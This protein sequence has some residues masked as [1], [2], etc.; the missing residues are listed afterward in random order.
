VRLRGPAHRKQ[1]YLVG[2]AA[3]G[4]I[5]LALV[6]LGASS[7]RVAEI[8]LLGAGALVAYA[9]GYFLQRK[10]RRVSLRRRLRVAGLGAVMIAGLLVALAWNAHR[11]GELA[12]PVV[13][14][15]L[16]ACAAAHLLGQALAYRRRT[17]PRRPARESALAHRYLDGLRGVKI[18]GSIHNP[19]GLNTLNADYTASTDT[20]FKQAE[21]EITGKALPVDIVASGDELPLGNESVDFVV[22]SHVLEHLPDPI[23]ALNEW[24]RVVRPGGYVF[25]IVPHKERTFD[26]DRPRTALAE[27]VHRHETGECPDTKEHCSVWITEDVVELVRHLNY[28][29]VEV[30]DVDDK[31]GNGFTV[32]IQ[33]GARAETP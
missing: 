6:R 13:G 5:V 30:Q 28:P 10:A 2:A 23:K 26:R 18:G 12:F 8:A 4:V 25:M 24:Y 27:L 33:K 19:F 14:G 1:R 21:I 31:V 3:L 32:V 15:G 9:L 20:V 29:I 17:R 7:P 22:S 11:R 16:A